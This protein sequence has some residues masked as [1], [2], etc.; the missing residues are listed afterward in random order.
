MKTVNQKLL[1]YAEYKGLSQRQFT[2]SLGLSEGVLRKGK[3]L[4]SGYLKRIKEKYHDLNMN[5][6]LYD[7]GQ[8]ILDLRAMAMEGAPFYGRECLKCEQLEMELVLSKE[9][10]VAKDETIAILKQQL[11]I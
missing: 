3:N 6:L 9:L 8:M 11:D 5:W 4:G 7:E 1:Q 10:L 2:K